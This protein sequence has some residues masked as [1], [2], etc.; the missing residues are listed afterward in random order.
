MRKQNLGQTMPQVIIYKELCVLR[1]PYPVS[2][3]PYPVY[4]LTLASSLEGKSDPHRIQ[5]T[6]LNPLFPHLLL[7]STI[8]KSCSTA[9][10]VTIS[11]RFGVTIFNCILFSNSSL[12]VLKIDKH[13]NILYKVEFFLD[14]VVLKNLYY[15]LY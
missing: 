12:A 2:R 7:V 10:S 15:K 4:H 1:T 5:N 9:F 14:S 11:L 8:T 3:T 13:A 6:E